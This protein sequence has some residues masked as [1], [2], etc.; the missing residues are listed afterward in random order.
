MRDY[1]FTIIG[2]GYGGFIPALRLS[3][4]GF[5]VVVLEKGKKFAQADF[6]QSYS[7]A[8]FRDLY[9]CYYTSDYQAFFTTARTLGGGSVLNAGASVKAPSETFEATREGKRLWPTSIS[10][11]TLEPYYATVERELGIR[12]IKWEEVSKVGGKFAKILTEAGL[13]CDRVAFN[14]EDCLQCGY[15]Q[16]GCKF[17]RKNTG[18]N[19]Y[20]AKSRLLG[21]EYITGATVVQIV[22]RGDWFE[23]IYRQGWREK[24]V[25]SARV[26]LAAGTLANVKILNDSRASL[27]AISNMLGKRF[28]TSGALSFLI[29]L[30]EA[31][32]TY[33]CYMGQTNPGVYSYEH[34]D[35]HRIALHATTVPLAV[36]GAVPLRYP[37]EQPGLITGEDFKHRVNSLFPHKVIGGAVHGLLNH[38]GTVRVVGGRLRI[39]YETSDELRRYV[40]T[41]YKLLKK[42]CDQAGAKLLL[43]GHDSEF[44][45]S[46]TL[47]L[48]T[49]AMADSA[50]AGVVDQAGQVYGCPGLFITDGSTIPASL[51]VNPYFTIAANAERLAAEI[52][53]AH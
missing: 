35:A 38:T 30:A 22:K 4:S 1:D 8:Y 24:K 17:G 7:P 3:E 12:Q 48:G 49:C 53:A 19:T 37:G 28:N 51:G 50:E 10:R 11:K 20:I 33:F 18:V 42:M 13:S 21:A 31:D 47:V 34:W 36:L 40:H 29:E 6:K 43:T 44:D 9:D 2:S 16:A 46:T 23:V 14:F 41:A 45:L 32:P 15:C 39:E 52:I 26:I 5:S 25:R 27:P